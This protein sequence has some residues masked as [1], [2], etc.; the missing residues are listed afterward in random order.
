[1]PE[2]KPG[3]SRNSP[4]NPG[5]SRVLDV[6]AWRVER[7]KELLA[8]RMAVPVEE[9]RRRDEVITERL[10]DHFRDLRGH[11]VGFCWPFRGEVD[12]RFAIRYFRGGGG[13]A[14]MPVVVTKDAPLEFREWWPGAPVIPGAFGL[15]VP[16]TPAIALDAVLVP[17][18]GFDAQ[19]YRLGYGG[20]YFDRTLASLANRPVTIAVAC[21]L[22]RIETIHPQPHD[23]PMDY[24]VT[25]ESLLDARR[26]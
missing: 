6:A 22:S 23:I 10:I 21:E 12:P 24:V 7:R 19:G 15:P 18:V 13:R 3:Q 1:M 14:A 11:V 26:H 5:Q 9:R 25:E 4:E 2:K 16:Q 20:G 8:L 17:P